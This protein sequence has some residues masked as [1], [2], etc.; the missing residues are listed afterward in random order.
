MAHMS[1]ELKQ[2][3]HALSQDHNKLFLGHL[4]K[5]FAYTKMSL[6]IYIYIYIYMW[7]LIIIIAKLIR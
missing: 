7:F 6:Y 1:P 3:N 4:V 5:I 2:N